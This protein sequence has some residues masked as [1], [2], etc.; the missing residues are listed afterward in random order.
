MIVT[1]KIAEFDCLGDLILE[2]GSTVR[3]KLKREELY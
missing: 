1:D 2:A 3:A